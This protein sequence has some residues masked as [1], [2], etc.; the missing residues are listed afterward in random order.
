MAH[1][2]EFQRLVGQLRTK[3]ERQLF[4]HTVY[5]YYYPD[6]LQELN[7]LKEQKQSG[8]DGGKLN[9]KKDAPTVVNSLIRQFRLETGAKSGNNEKLPMQQNIN[10]QKITAAYNTIQKNTEL[11]AEDS[12]EQFYNLLVQLNSSEAICLETM[13][14]P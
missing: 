8:D 14:L 7:R 1:P 5:M 9:K 2:F 6:V 13:M 4:L 10:T 3:Q 12:Y 11:L